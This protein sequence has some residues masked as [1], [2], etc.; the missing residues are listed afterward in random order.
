MTL[1]GR[2]Y[3]TACLRLNARD[4]KL[5]VSKNGAISTPKSARNGA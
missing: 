3:T 5:V 4:K 1:S 2:R